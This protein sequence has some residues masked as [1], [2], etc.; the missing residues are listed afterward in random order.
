[1]FFLS[2]LY[3]LVESKLTLYFPHVYTQIFC[4]HFINLIDSMSRS[5][6]STAQLTLLKSG[7]SSP[8]ELDA[9]GKFIL[10]HGWAPATTR[11]YAAAVNKFLVFLS[12]TEH[13]GAVQPYTSKLVYQFIL[14]CSAASSKK[15]TASTIK[16]YLT[17]LR[18]W[19]SLHGRRFPLVDTHR[20]RLLLKSC[21]RTQTLSSGKIRVGLT[22][23]DVLTMTDLLTTTSKMDLVTKSIILVGFWGLARLGELTENRDHPTI[24]IRRKDLKFYA[25][26]TRARIALRQAKT[27][28]PGEIQFLHLASQPNRLDPINALHLLVQRIPGNPEDPLFP[29]TRPGRPMHRSL[30]SAFL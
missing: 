12:T 28:K 5:P 15:V 2:H 3:I 23:R 11:Q 20:V 24:F 26:G 29:G 30:I 17:G 19:H 27:A 6:L 14:W 22:L 8:S 7:V 9:P 4:T 10:E 16:R 1:M 13:S 21:T 25:G 18:M